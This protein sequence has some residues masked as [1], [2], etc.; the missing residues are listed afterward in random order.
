MRHSD[1]SG[2]DD[3]EEEFLGF[4]GLSSSDVEGK[5]EILEENWGRLTGSRAHGQSLFLLLL[6]VHE[7]KNATS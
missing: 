3:N 2:K 1:F 5:I 7:A 4:E 6:G